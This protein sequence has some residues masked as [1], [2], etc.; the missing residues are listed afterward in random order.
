[1][2]NSFRRS[3]SLALC[4]VATVAI[5]DANRVVGQPP[6]GSGSITG[7]VSDP[8]IPDEVEPGDIVTFEVPEGTDEE[9]GVWTISG[10]VAGP[11]PNSEPVQQ[12]DGG[13]LP[14]Y[15]PLQEPPTG[16]AKVEIPD[17]N[18][19]PYNPFPGQPARDLVGLVK[20]KDGAPLPA[21]VAVGLTFA[22]A[23]LIDPSWAACA[24]LPAS[25]GPK[26]QEVVKGPFQNEGVRDPPPIADMVV[27]LMDSSFEATGRNVA[28]QVLITPIGKPGIAIDEPGVKPPAD[29]G[30]ASVD[31]EGAKN[32]GPGGRLTRYTAGVR[33]PDP[34]SSP[35]SVDRQLD[36]DVSYYSVTL[37]D[38]TEAVIEIA[39][40][41]ATD[42]IVV[43]GTYETVTVLAARPTSAESDGTARKVSTGTTITQTEMERRGNGWG[44]MA[45]SAIRCQTQKAP[46]RPQRTP[47]Q[48]ADSSRTDR[49]VGPMV[50]LDD[51][52]RAK[53]VS[54]RWAAGQAP[55]PCAELAPQ[56][57]LL[58]ALHRLDGPAA[59]TVAKKTIDPNQPKEALTYAVTDLRAGRGVKLSVAQAGRPYYDVS[60]FD[61]DSKGDKGQTLYSFSTS[62]G[63]GAGQSGGQL[64][65][66]VCKDDGSCFN[67]EYL[68]SEDIPFPKMEAPDRMVPTPP[69]PPNSLLRLAL[70]A[71]PTAG[72]CRFLPRP[73]TGLDVG[74]GR[75]Q[76]KLSDDLKPGEPLTV[77]YT[78]ATGKVRVNKTMDKVKIVPRQ[79]PPR[80][81]RPQLISMPKFSIAGQDV[82]GRGYFPGAESRNSFWMDQQ[83][84]RA[85]STSSRL[86]IFPLAART[87]PG[88]HTFRGDPKVGFAEDNAVHTTVLAVAGSVA[89][90][91]LRTGEK[92]TITLTVKGTNEPVAL[93]LENRSEATIS[94]GQKDQTLRTSGGS[95]NQVQR[96]LQ[97]LKPGA[98]DL[99]YWIEGDRCPSA[100]TAN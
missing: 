83:P 98:W 40:A 17:P 59:L 55:I 3:G 7:T 72:G 68:P 84:I 90:P 30:T 27:R 16:R 56:V 86:A 23:V 10:T 58:Q 8:Q 44:A 14:P 78:D 92:T 88:P 45:L 97:S 11:E 39:V 80:D 38:K 6:A 67:Y 48:V 64:Y 87:A 60:P 26:P 62:K 29:A 2:R 70:N 81:P 93:H 66:E 24:G 99:A 71:E 35:G 5:A 4:L 12:G 49:P 36:W 15:D 9:G 79:P 65:R 54:I 32:K 31:M 22:N 25:S 89:K 47:D 13:Y 50:N 1:M 53:P 43:T 76:V 94:V 74:T 96:E 20:D 33:R 42:Q 95:M 75:F 69:A 51:F 37:P 28:L 91:N 18:P 46:E 19:P 57:A 77:S 21:S 85:K 73:L 63:Q 82:C 52:P 61:A 41:P 100:G 34:G